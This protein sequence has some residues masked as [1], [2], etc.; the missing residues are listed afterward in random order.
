MVANKVNIN[1]IE[2]CGGVIFEEIIGTSRKEVGPGNIALVSR[3][4][5]Y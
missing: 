5:I 3:I 4:N 1:L 2:F